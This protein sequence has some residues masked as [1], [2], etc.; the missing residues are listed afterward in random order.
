M[1]FDSHTHLFGPQHIGGAMKAA[2]KRAWGENCDIIATPEQHLANIGGFDGGI[3][4]AM[5]AAATGIVVPN[6]YVAEYVGK[7]PTRLFG[8][9]SVDPNKE[10]AAGLLEQAIKEYKLSGL[11]L[12]PIYQNFY[13]DSKAHYPL[14]AKADELK[15][16]IL[17]HQG[18]SFVPEGYLDAS[19]PAALDP[20]AR[21]FP[22]LKM[23]IAHMGHPWIGECISVVR[24]HPNLYMDI[25]ALG[26]R[27]WQFYNAMVL[28]MEYGVLDK[29]LFGSDYPFFT[30]QMTLDSFRNI[31]A[32]VEGSKMP[33]IPEKAIESIIHRNTPELLGLA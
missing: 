33:H 7:H 24:K 28:A 23:I 19:R 8:F 30:T 1:I 21:T 13:P 12:G 4:L 29:I 10:N 27:P 25:S 18:T 11:K 14:Y 2:A 3:V 6:D 26:S 9:A 31:N 22:N 17:W 20:I 15:L 5:D 16:P 32:L